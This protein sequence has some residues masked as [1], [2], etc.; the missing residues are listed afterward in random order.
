[1][2]TILLLAL[3]TT[4][5]AGNACSISPGG[6]NR[7]SSMVVLVDNKERGWLGVSIEDITSSLARRKNLESREGVYVRDVEDDSPADVAGIREGD[8][9]TE[10]D[11]RKVGDSEDL[12]ENVRKTKPGTEVLVGVLRDG[13]RRSLKATVEEMPRRF[14]YVPRIPAQ[15]RMRSA[16]DFLFHRSAALRGLVLED[17]NKQLGEYFG[18]PGGRGVLVKNVKHDSE[19]EKAG[20][21]AGDV[22]VKIGLEPV[23]DIDDIRQSLRDY[24]EGD[25]AEFEILRRGNTQ[26]ISLIIPERDRDLSFEYF[27]GDGEDDVIIDLFTPEEGDFFREDAMR[28]K[29]EMRRMKLELRD[30]MKDL[31]DHLR[32]KLDEHVRLS[33]TV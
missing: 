15:P 11:G 16:P 23:R 26:K 28:L 4:I 19:G 30:S 27:H 20:F 17:L 2:K 6:G 1:M 29:R 13:E 7:P 10:F 8:I 25:K 31:K 21:K 32:E 3:S 5:F 18:A 24:K 33:V 9:I 12:V 22:I 14:T